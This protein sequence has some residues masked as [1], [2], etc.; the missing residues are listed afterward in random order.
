MRDNMLS[1]VPIVDKGRLVGLV[2]QEDLLDV[3]RDVLME[4]LRED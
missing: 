1:C 2:T 4:G 3:A